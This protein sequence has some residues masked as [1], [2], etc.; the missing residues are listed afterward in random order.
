VRH[1][2][3]DRGC[4]GRGPDVRYF[5]AFGIGAAVGLVYTLG[6]IT[7]AWADPK[8][9]ALLETALNEAALTLQQARAAAGGRPT[10]SLEGYQASPPDVSELIARISAVRHQDDLPQ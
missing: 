4:Q 2:C 3:D 9:K 10:G 6:R 7:W 5:V 1:E 8:G